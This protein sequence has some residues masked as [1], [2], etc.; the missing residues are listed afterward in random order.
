MAL[1]H[2]FPSCWMKHVSEKLEADRKGQANFFFPI[3][4]HICFCWIFPTCKCDH[5]DKGRHS[6]SLKKMLALNI[7]VGTGLLWK[8]YWIRRKPWR[9]VSASFCLPTFLPPREK[10]HTQGICST[11]QESWS[12]LCFSS[13]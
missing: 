4:W 6:F 5:E 3:L 11:F 10:K 8:L 2:Y 9:K 13:P 7:F 12:L 1:F